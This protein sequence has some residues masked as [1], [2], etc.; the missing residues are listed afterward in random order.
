[1]PA[2]TLDSIAKREASAKK[3]LKGLEGDKLKAA[4][5]SLKRIQR[6]RRSLAVQEERRKPKAK[7]GEAAA[8]A[9]AAE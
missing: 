2:K 1:M 3:A 7:P 6:K 9:A 4:R 5:K 8:A